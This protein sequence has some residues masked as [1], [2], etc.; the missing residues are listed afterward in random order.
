VLECKTVQV[1]DAGDHR[2]FIGEAVAVE[3]T[4]SQPHP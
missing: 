2:V 3:T 4:H 1:F